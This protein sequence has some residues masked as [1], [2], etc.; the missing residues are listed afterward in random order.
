MG[1]WASGSAAHASVSPPV[2]RG[3]RGQAPPLSALPGPVVITRVEKRLVHTEGP[4]GHHT[5]G[6]A[7]AALPAMGPFRGF[8]PETH[9]RRREDAD[10]AGRGPVKLGARG[11]PQRRLRARA[12]VADSPQPCCVGPPPAGSCSDTELEKGDKQVEARARCAVCARTPPPPTPLPRG[13]PPHGP[14]R[15]GNEIQRGQVPCPLS[16][17]TTRAVHHLH[18]AGPLGSCVS[19]DGRAP[20]CPSVVS[21]RCQHSNPPMRA[22]KCKPH[23][24]RLHFPGV[25]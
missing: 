7:P 9:T 8:H 19:V 13:G 11:H 10:R 25:P 22:Q 5:R 4:G 3:C 17:S 24:P 1:P 16:P 14:Y 6:C 15:P 2:N 20:T 18:G 21:T 12:T 23:R